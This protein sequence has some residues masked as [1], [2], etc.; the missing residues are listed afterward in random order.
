M[1]ATFADKHSHLFSDDCDAEATENKLEYTEVYQEFQQIFE[2]KIEG[3]GS[4]I[5]M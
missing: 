2:K 4:M 5:K 1:F 3:R